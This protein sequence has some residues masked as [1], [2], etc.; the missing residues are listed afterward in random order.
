MSEAKKE[1]QVTTVTTRDGKIVE[2]AGK[3]KMLKTSFE[4]EGKIVTRLDFLNGEFREF[5]IPDT[6]LNKFAAHGAEQ[7]LGD[8]I[9]GVDDVE[10]CVLAIDSLIDRLYN[11][12]WAIKRESSGMSGTSVLLRA[13]VEVTGKSVEAIKAFLSTKTPAEK[14][15][16]RNSAKIQPVVQRLEAE[17][18]AGKSTINTDELLAELN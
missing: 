18:A 8:E 2:F 17:K 5:T 11:G 10:D 12:Q 1:T 4:R 13:L 9:A 15:A 6:L 3:R 14:I 7:K 16:L